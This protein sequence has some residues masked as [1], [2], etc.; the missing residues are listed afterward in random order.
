MPLIIWYAGDQGL[1][2]QVETG[3]DRVL[4]KEEHRVQ[5]EE[6]DQMLDRIL[7]DALA[8]SET[9]IQGDASKDFLSYW[10]VGSS[11]QESGIFQA[12]GFKNERLEFLWRAMARK[13]RTGARTDGS[14]EPRWMRLRSGGPEPRREGN[15]LD[16][17]SMCRWLAEQ[18]LEDALLTFGGNV[19]N[20][21]QML[22]RTSLRSLK[23]RTAFGDWLRPQSAAAR[24]QLY[25]PA[26]FAEMMKTLRGRWPARGPGSAKKPIHYQV[27]E[28]RIMIG[29]LLR[30]FGADSATE[31][32]HILE[33]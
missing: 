18:D 23:F 16:H 3:W 21:W 7:D 8:R 4:T 31:P 11:L 6:I 19:R 24:A 26:T 33:G 25:R 17:F 14:V 32:R 10:A 22:E 29:E 15:A 28:L 27:E 20:V 5:A 12:P 30:S 1:F 9:R 13:C 2:S